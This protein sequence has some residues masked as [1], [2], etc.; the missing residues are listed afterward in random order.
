MDLGIVWGLFGDPLGVYL[1]DF[2]E[3]IFLIFS[4]EQLYFLT[5]FSDYSKISEKK[6]K[7]Y[8]KSVQNQYKNLYFLLL[9][10]LL[11]LKVVH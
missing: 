7:I 5:V 6:R 11:L 4:Y 8:K 1:D 9:L 3:H 10:L 2:R